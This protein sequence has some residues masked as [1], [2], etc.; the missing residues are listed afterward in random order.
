MVMS[1]KNCHRLGTGSGLVP[2][3]R[4]AGEEIH[5]QQATATTQPNA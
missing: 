4:A 5:D 3:W 2:D 1:S